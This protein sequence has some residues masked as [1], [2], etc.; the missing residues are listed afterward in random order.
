MNI[1]EESLNIDP[2]NIINQESNSI[3]INNSYSQLNKEQI[4]NKL[5]ISTDLNISNKLSKIK[6]NIGNV[7]NVSVDDFNR[8]ENFFENWAGINS[9]MFNRSASKTPWIPDSSKTNIFLPKNSKTTE[10]NDYQFD[11]INEK[12]N[13]SFSK[14]LRLN[15][16]MRRYKQRREND[17]ALPSIGRKGSRANTTLKMFFNNTFQPENSQVW[18]TRNHSGLAKHKTIIFQSLEAIDINE[19]KNDK[20]GKSNIDSIRSR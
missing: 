6:E 9:I 15:K 12:N 17:Q 14:S 3:N 7:I 8:K 11:E 20:W 10:N 19:L 1:R 13:K 2:I 4:Q 16:K 5:N 18:F